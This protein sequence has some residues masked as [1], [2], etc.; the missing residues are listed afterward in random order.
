M[1]DSDRLG[2]LEIDQNALRFYQIRRRL[3]D[4]WE[5]TEQLASDIQTEKE[6]AETGSL[7]KKELKALKS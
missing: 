7:L 2:G 5:F 4:I 3:E 6:K 1:V